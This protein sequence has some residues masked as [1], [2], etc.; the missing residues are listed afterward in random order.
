MHDRLPP[1]PPPVLTHGEL[2]LGNTI[3]GRYV[4]DPEVSLADRELDVAYLQM[5]A[6]APFPDA[7]WS[8]YLAV[9]PLPHGYV[10]RRPILELH[11][12]L[13]QV[14]HFGAG[15]LPALVRTLEMIGC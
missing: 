13:L 7:F 3:A 9:L 5:S 2:W 8:S 15:Q 12:R 14:R 10:E 4:I 1:H 11:H 6:R